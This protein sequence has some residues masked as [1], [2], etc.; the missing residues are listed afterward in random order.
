MVDPWEPRIGEWL[1]SP[2]RSADG[3]PVTTLRILTSALY[4]EVS[5]SS[6]KEALRVAAVM[7]RLGYANHVARVDG[8]LSR[9]WRAVTA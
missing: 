3:V 7:R 1:T 8:K 2:E 4:F 9:V 6:P 5:H